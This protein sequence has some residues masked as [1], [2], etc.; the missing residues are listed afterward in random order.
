[1]RSRPRPDAEPHEAHGMFETRSPR[2]GRT[3][4]T[5]RR[6]AMLTVPVA[7]LAGCSEQQPA[8]SAAGPIAVQASD[9]ACSLARTEVDA[10]TITF[11]VSNKGSKVTEFYLY[12]EGDRIV[13]E[14]ENIG[15]GATRRLIVEVP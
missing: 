15:P 10:G 7:V 13:G 4:T 11:E 6:A 5:L 3:M 12:G 1:R 14:V 8:G 9:T 2:R